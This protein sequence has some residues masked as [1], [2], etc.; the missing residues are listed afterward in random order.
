MRGS[1]PG[2]GLGH[3]HAAVGQPAVGDVDLAPVDDP[4]VAVLPGVGP[5]A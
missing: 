5:D 4:V 1:G 2:P 3:H